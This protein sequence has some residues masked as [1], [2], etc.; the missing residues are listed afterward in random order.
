[1]HTTRSSIRRMIIMATIGASVLVHAGD[2]VVG[3]EP[4]KIALT[5]G[6][7]NAAF[8]FTNFITRSGDK[9]MDGS[10]E[11]RFISITAPSLHA[12]GVSARTDPWEMQDALQLSLIH[13]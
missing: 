9:L 1:M 11:L 6:I 3:G 5:N 4:A 10:R 7:N 2:G 12:N 13:I 8:G